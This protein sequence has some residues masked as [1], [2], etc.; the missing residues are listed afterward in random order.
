[1]KKIFFITV[2]VSSLLSA[3]M[4][5]LRTVITPNIPYSIADIQF[6]SS[7]KGWIVGNSG[8][9]MKSTDGGVSWTAQNSG[10]T[11]N[12]QRAC[13]VN[14]QVGY[15]SI[16]AKSS[17][18]RTS[19]GGATWQPVNLPVSPSTDTVRTPYAICFTSP[20]TGFVGCGKSALG[21][22][23]MTID[24]G[25]AFAKMREYVIASSRGAS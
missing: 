13:F 3:Q 8:M 23:F 22:I 17:I 4:N 7:S 15:V 16:S 10:V 6:I 18:L 19:D 11:N 5:G 25:K 14:D 24:S 21:D 1:M 2:M 9:I 12:L 20:S